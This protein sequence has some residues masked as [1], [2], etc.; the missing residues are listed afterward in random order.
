MNKLELEIGRTYFQLTYAD[1]DMTMPCVEPLVYLGLTDSSTFHIFQDTVSYV[2]FG[3]RLNL[4]HDHD[5]IC[6]YFISPEEIGSNIVALEQI[7]DEISEAVQRARVLNNPT[8]VV[9]REGWKSV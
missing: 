1:C 4:E 7:A 6:V 9:I 2:R 3:S 8:L 5:E